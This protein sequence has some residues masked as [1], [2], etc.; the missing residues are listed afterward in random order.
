M[1]PR[2]ALAGPWIWMAL[3]TAGTGGR[4]GFLARAGLLDLSRSGRRAGPGL[5]GSQL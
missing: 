3:D 2:P 5:P 4:R 1:G